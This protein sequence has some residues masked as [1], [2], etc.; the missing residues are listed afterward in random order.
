MLWRRL[1]LIGLIPVLALV[2]TRASAAQ[3]AAPAQDPDSVIEKFL[4]ASGGRDA[5]SKLSG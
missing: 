5:L 1:A 3:S 2:L 4:A